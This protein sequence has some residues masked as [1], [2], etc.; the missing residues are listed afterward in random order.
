[1]KGVYWSTTILRQVQGD[2]LRLN[3]TLFGQSWPHHKGADPFPFRYLTSLT[4]YERQKVQHLVFLGRPVSAPAML[5][6]CAHFPH[7]M[8]QRPFYPCFHTTINQHVADME[9]RYPFLCFDIRN[10][11]FH[12]SLQPGDFKGKT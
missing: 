4:E 7:P 1:M 5:I 9:H 12:S 8:I 3:Y 2:I 10:S 6:T 11:P